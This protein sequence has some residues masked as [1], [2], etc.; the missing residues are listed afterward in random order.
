MKKILA[1]LLLA[2]APLTAQSADLANGQEINKSCALCHGNIGQGTPGKLSP[3]LAG[4]PKDYLVKIIKEYRDG[5]RINPLMT[6]SPPT[7]R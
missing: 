1:F 4:I 5:V 7:C 2:V 6:I 3:R